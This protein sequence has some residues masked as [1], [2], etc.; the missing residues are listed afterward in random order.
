[1][2]VAALAVVLIPVRT[3]GA[4]AG[5]GF[6]EAIK[7]LGIERR[8][9]AEGKQKGL[10]DPFKPED[11]EEVARLKELQRD[12]FEDFKTHVRER[13]GKRLKGD[14]EVLFNGDVWTGSRALELG[15]IDGLGD[16]RTVLRDRFGENVKLRPVGSSRGWFRRRVGFAL[17]N[18]ANVNASEE[19]VGG[20][21]NALEAR[22]LWA[23]YGI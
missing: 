17:N 13:R 12:I 16:F 18:S 22:A 2:T 4:T 21:I 15:L 11:A 20:F 10:L 19:M 8:V 6:Q 1:M 23:R 5:F 7:R 3:A 14:Q 9:Y